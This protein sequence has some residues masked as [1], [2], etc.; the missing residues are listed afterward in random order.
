M[1][2]FGKRFRPGNYKRKKKGLFHVFLLGYV[3]LV[4]PGQTGY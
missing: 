4:F 1:N 3:C 2:I